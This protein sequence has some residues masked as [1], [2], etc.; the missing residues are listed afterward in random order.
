MCSYACVVRGCWGGVLIVLPSRDFVMSSLP[1]FL[2]DFVG[3]VLSLL[4]GLQF[5]LSKF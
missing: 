5:P 3:Y 4:P 1:L 2:F